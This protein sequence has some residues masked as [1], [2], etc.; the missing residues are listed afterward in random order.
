M[1]STALGPVFFTS[2]SAAS[3]APV[4]HIAQSAMTIRMICVFFFMMGCRFLGPAR[5]PQHGGHGSMLEEIFGANAWNF[6]D[7]GHVYHRLAKM[8]D[9]DAGQG[10]DT[11]RGSASVHEVRF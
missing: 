8:T 2:D 5:I 7:R 1:G 3:A 4:I 9:F 10:G 11:P 6:F